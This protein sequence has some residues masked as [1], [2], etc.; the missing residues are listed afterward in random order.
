M[1]KV[2]MHFNTLAYSNPPC[3]LSPVSLPHSGEEGW[4]GGRV[5]NSC[6]HVPACS[7]SDRARRRGAWW[8]AF[9]RGPPSTATMMW[10]KMEIALFH[11]HYISLGRMWALLTHYRR[12]CFFFFWRT[13]TAEEIFQINNNSSKNSWVNSLS[14]ISE[15]S[16]CCLE[17]MMAIIHTQ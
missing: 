6:T 17:S 16:K 10:V 3:S 11:R 13:N 5:G 8:I 14:T 4:G 7:C 2:N 1:D 9:H 12:V 15:G